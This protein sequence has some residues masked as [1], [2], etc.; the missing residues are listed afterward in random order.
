ML[1][2]ACSGSNP[3]ADTDSGTPPSDPPGSGAGQAAL[4]YVDPFIGTQGDHGQL[5][6]S[7][8]VPFG[9]VKLGPDTGG[10][11][12][13]GYQYQNRTLLGFSHTR[14]GGIGCSGV[15]GTLLLLPALEQSDSA[16]YDK[17]SEQAAP[18]YYTVA[19]SGGIRADLTASTRVGLHRYTY[20]KNRGNVLVHVDT[21]HSY[22]P[23]NGSA[24]QQLD[25][26]TLGGY[27]DAGNACAK[28][29]N[30]ATKRYKLYYA[31]RF[32][33]PIVALSADGDGKAW[34]DFGASGDG[35]VLS[36][37]VALSPIDVETATAELE[38]DMPGWDFDAARARAADRWAEALG[39][40]EIVDDRPETAT[41]RTL[42]Y[43]TLYRSLLAPS[44]VTS[45]TGLYRAAG[46]EAHVRRI[47]DVAPDYVNYAGWSTWDDY[48]RYALLTLAYPDTARN[49]ARSIVELYREGHATSDG[50][51]PAPT[52]RNEFMGAVL[53]DAYKKDI[54]GFDLAAAYDAGIPVYGN[55]Q[56]EQPY[57]NYLNLRIAEALGRTQ[58]L[59][60]LREKALAYRQY[61]AADQKDADGTV[62]GFF[63]PDGKIVPQRSVEDVGGYFYQGNLWHYRVL[64]PH[65][66][67]GLAALRGSAATLADD[68]EFYFDTWRHQALNETPLGFPFVFDY[69]GKPWLTQKWSRMYT[70]ET[71][72]SLYSTYNRFLLPIVRPVYQA[73]PDG[74][75][76]G[77]DDDT[78]A[79]SA[80]FVFQALGL[81]PL[82][83]GDPY[84]VI[85]SPIFPQAHI[86][87]PGGKRFT[88]RADGVSEQ[89]FYIQ[90]ATLNG[91]PYDKPW[92]EH[93][94][95]AADGELVLKM[96]PTPNT[97]W[98]SDP[99]LA[100]P[101]LSTQGP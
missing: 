79:M 56:L 10:S 81:Y 77:M 22:T 66:I 75:L 21:T 55:E 14:M 61:W 25:A 4:A 31:L 68:L 43:T 54:G 19:T 92:I 28:D 15:G 51:W 23:I 39:H 46:D 29:D 84:Y 42:F 67:A 11:G 101:S 93:S 58:D 12:H 85:G 80:Q 86:N 13:T 52:V 98:G 33:R 32:D 73:K 35:Q 26:Q 37:K 45:S 49:L 41:F 17:S 53:L 97:S 78:G 95:V 62:R 44:D 50:Y 89:N 91:Q 76:I 27:V 59:P 16:R 1:L 34:V 48:R 7:A 40:I 5:D 71:V 90:S 60:A 8:V 82:C 94:L 72:H 24:L 47:S 57:G 18:G 96:G 3:P 6:P 100:P 65:D 38:A 36:A 70:T 63:T 99:A 74:W 20:P 87:L 9:L 88:I 64:V 30:K 69:L 83:V 2:A